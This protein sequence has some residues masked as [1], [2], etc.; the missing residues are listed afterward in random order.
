MKTVEKLK[1]P[2]GGWGEAGELAGA[3]NAFTR[4]AGCRAAA[5]GELAKVFIFV[6]CILM[7]FVRHHPFCARCGSAERAVV[8]GA[9]SEQRSPRHSASSNPASESAL[10]L[11]LAAGSRSSLAQAWA[12]S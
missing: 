5:R 11:V 1:A 4:L 3:V 2:A 10:C 6:T 9:W 7:A 12:Q 8:W